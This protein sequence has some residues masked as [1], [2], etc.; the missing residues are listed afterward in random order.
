MNCIRCGEPHENEGR[1]YCDACI[2]RCGCGAPTLAHR[3]TCSDGCAARFHG[4]R[5]G[6]QKVERVPCRSCGKSIP[7]YRATCSMACAQALKAA[8]P[9]GACK[10]CGAPC[11]GRKTCSDACFDAIVVRRSTVGAR[12]AAV[13]AKRREAERH[14]YRGKDKA[15]VVAGLTAKQRG[16]C[17]VCGGYGQKRGDGTEGLVLDHCH[18]T[19]KPRAMLC[20]RCNAA[21]G[22]LGE[23]PERIKAMW[24]YARSWAQAVLH[25]AV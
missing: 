19:G 16:K 8:K 21:L 10:V 11:R 6:A 23:S 4:V 13:R 3:K 15:A 22:L 12:S 2:P 20:G 17:K 5:T 1:R 24:D 9:H 14:A 7:G 18:A 25:V